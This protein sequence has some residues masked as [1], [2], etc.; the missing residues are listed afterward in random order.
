MGEPKNEWGPARP[1][2]LCVDDDTRLR[3]DLVEELEAADFE[4]MQA[5]NGAEAVASLQQQKPDLILCDITMPVMGGYDLLRY[6]REKRPD[7]NDVPFIFLSVLGDRTEII[8]GKSGGADDYLTKPVD[9]G[10][11]IAT[12]RA[13]LAQVT[14]MRRA[15]IAELERERSA[16]LETA[17][18]GTRTAIES[19]A[20]V[21]DGL[22]SG[23]IVLDEN[24]QVQFMNRTAQLIVEEKDGLILAAGQLRT[25]LQK[26][27][28]TLRQTIHD[29]LERSEQSG[30]V[31]VSKEFGR[32]LLLQIFP[33]AGGSAQGPMEVAVFVLDPE[34]RPPLDQK[35]VAQMYGLTPAEARLATAIADGKRLEEISDAFQVS[36][37]T[38]SFHLQNLFR[39][40][41]TSRQT[42]LVALLIRSALTLQTDAAP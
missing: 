22:S 28:R 18:Q 7:L 5:G 20:R 38:I 32:P 25:T 33:L 6:V 15:L 8:Q 13:R 23:L 12:V 36:Q 30:V 2:I 9:F 42:D 1:V 21:L 17:I 29:V 37:T 35:V 39:K 40:T 31:T 16:L 14:R 3:T 24:S 26:A 10:H 34:R 19:M 41:Q 27:T 11:M 4:V